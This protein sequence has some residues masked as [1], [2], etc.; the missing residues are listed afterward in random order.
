MEREDK[1]NLNPFGSRGPQRSRLREGSGGT[2]GC[3]GL[4]AGSPRGPDHVSSLLP[5][6]FPHPAQSGGTR[7]FHRCECIAVC[8][9]GAG[10]GSRGSGTAERERDPR[11]DGS[12]GAGGHLH[13]PGLSSP[14][15]TGT[16]VFI[17]SDLTR[18]GAH[19]SPP[20]CRRDF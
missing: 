20:R 16:A 17:S 10:C 8:A 6:S 1:K 14:S 12:G 13:P 19:L 5:R 2:A 15:K 4:P 9:G 11:D 7:G 18:I 3:S